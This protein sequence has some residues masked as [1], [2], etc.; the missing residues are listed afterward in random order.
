MSQA[1]KI[2][3]YVTRGKE[4]SSKQEVSLSLMQMEGKCYCYGKGGH[5]SSICCYK[6]KPKSEWAINKVQQNFSQLQVD[7][8]NSLVTNSQITSRLN[9]YTQQSQPL[10]ITEWPGAHIA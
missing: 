4:S 9:W 8:S 6:D 1:T 5:I 3:N 2:K 7:T 10:V